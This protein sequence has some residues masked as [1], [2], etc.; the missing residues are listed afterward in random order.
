MQTERLE[1]V[2]MLR[3]FAALLVTYG[4]VCSSTL[5]LSEKYGFDF[6]RLYQPTGIGVD[7]FFGISGFIMVYASERLFT[8]DGAS[9]EFLSRRLIRIAPLYWLASLAFLLM[10]AVD[11]ARGGQFPSARAIAESLLFIPSMEFKPVH[12]FPYPILAAGWTLNYECFFYAVFAAFLF[13]RRERAVAAVAALLVAFV[14]LGAAIGPESTVLRFWTQPIVLE[15]AL[16]MAVAIARRRQVMLPSWLRVSMIVCAIAWVLAA[17]EVRSYGFERIAY[18]GLPAITVLAAV[19]LGRDPIPARFERPVA[20]L[21]DAS[22]SL[23]LL[24]P[25]LI[26]ALQHSGLH[27][28]GLTSAV[29]YIV[30]VV[31]AS[32]LLAIV[33]SQRVERPLVKLL[34]AKAASLWRKPGGEL[35]AAA[36]PPRR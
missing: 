12:G 35:A 19:V 28:L 18:W 24:H 32:C 1:S 23:Y 36:A 14:L 26:V 4:H 7:L 6:P 30:V 13:L 27:P 8:R 3:A 21:G 11:A 15:F 10:L 2:Q 16:G 22:Y 25:L 20:L 33:C 17:P 34:N 29:T 9:I 5:K 31:A